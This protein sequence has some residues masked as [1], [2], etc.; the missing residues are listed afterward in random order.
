MRPATPEEITGWDELVAANPDGGT[1]L[2][3]KA[4][5]EV[6]SRHGWQASHYL[7]DKVAVLV[8]RRQIPGF[9]ELWYVPNGPGVT[10]RGGLNRFAQ[11]AA[12]LQPAPF[13]IKIDPEIRRGEI[14]A[15]QL[16]QMGFVLAPRNLQYN[17]STVIVG[18]RPDEEAILGSFRQKT[19][20]NVRL[21]AK[22]GVSV[23][24]VPTDAST[25]NTMYSLYATTTRRAGVYLRSKRYFEDYW[26]L[27]AE[28]GHGQM[29][30]ASYEGKPLAGAFITF[31]G[32]K[33]LYKDG[34]SLREHTAVQAPY[35]LQ[36]EIMRWLKARGILDYDMHGVPP[37]DR[38]DDPTHPMAGLARFKTGFQP[39]VTEFIGTYDLPLDPAK[40]RRWC[41][42]AERLV[43][44]YEYRVRKRLFY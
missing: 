10:D 6:K 25:I 40:Y 21:A 27:H 9:G 2:Q 31:T 15:K 24:A 34:G 35:A 37:A 1:V 14:S 12:K 18:L 36:W 29:F 26:R 16:Q 39:Q 7:L 4:F 28:S 17:V 33:A 8:L 11:A 43:V 13:M 41:R 30:L 38:I 5:G 32:T 42:Y 22:K 23:A 20:Y 44:A 3:L 19:R